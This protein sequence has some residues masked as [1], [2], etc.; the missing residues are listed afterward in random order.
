MLR[1]K[2]QMVDLEHRINKGDFY[3]VF[4]R[5]PIPSEDNTIPLGGKPVTP[6]GEAM[7][8]AQLQRE[9]D[10]HQAPFVA[11]RSKVFG[12]FADALTARVKPR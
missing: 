4:G 6:D 2:S 11:T 12:T 8:G 3:L 7:Q 1:F 9:L 10:E 5:Q